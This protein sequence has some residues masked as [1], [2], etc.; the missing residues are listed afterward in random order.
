MTIFTALL[1]LPFVWLVCDSDV[2]LSDMPFSVFGRARQ[3][4]RG[5]R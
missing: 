4:R 5:G 2:V 1:M 3:I